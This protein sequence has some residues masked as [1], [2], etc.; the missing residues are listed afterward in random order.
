MNI[1]LTGFMGTGKT[2]V[3]R[4][5]AQ[6]LGYLFV[7]TD[8]RI[9]TVNGRSIPDI[10]R[11]E[12]EAAFRRYETAVAQ[13][14]GAKSGQV[15]ATGG[16]LMMFE[17]NV[18][19]LSEN[20]R[21]FC[22]TASVAEILRRVE[23]EGGVRP[24]L[25]GDDPAGKIQ[26][27]LSNRAEK[28]GRFPQIQTDNKTPE[29]IAGE[30]MSALKQ[31]R[32]K[33]AH[34][35]GEYEVV[36]GYDLIQQVRQ[37]AQIKGQMV[38][39]TDT[40]VGPLYA[41]QID[42]PVI[43]VP[44]GEEHKNLETVRQIYDEMFALGLDRKATAVALGGGVIGD[45]TGFVA[46]TYMRGIDFVQCPTTLLS[47][48]D[49]SVGGKTGVDMPQGKNLVGAFKQPTAVLAD[50]STLQT[51]SK[52][53]YASGMAEAIKHGL[54]VGGDLWK[55][56]ES[57]DWRL[58]ISPMTHDA[59]RNLVDVIQVKRDV[60][61]VDP[62]EQGIRATLNL[63][64]T[65]GHAIEHTSGYALRHGECVAVGLVAAANLSA[66]LGLCEAG[67]QAR[68]EAV[69][70]ATALP[71]RIPVGMDLEQVFAMMWHD[72]KKLAGKLRFIL[73]RDAGD[74]FVT[75]DVTETAVM[76]TLVELVERE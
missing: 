75:A 52:E 14:L 48:V 63:G 33:V 25:A 42:A 40:N 65:F 51:L 32:L 26:Q 16:G 22:L 41:Q 37:L 13:E 31:E 18:A 68:I 21:L 72:K 62:F 7:D 45:M 38:V 8:E 4:L 19:A 70:R 43:T 66:R 12:G 73:M 20:G 35:T 74:A 67:W 5:L 3:G 57:G 59:P 71:T 9:V 17:Q 54:L 29:Q 2:T 10:F 24:L 55:R 36:V 53:E 76:E 27:L 64:H 28:Y 34:P 15:I 46:A 61:Q 23:R 60:V 47:M 11:E 6:K 44:A 39:I 49:A 30:I 58:D 69:L 56:L 50:L 1:V